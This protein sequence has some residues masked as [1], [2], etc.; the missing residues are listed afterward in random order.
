MQIKKNDKNRN[1]R[2]KEKNWIF[3][4]RIP[5]I[6]LHFPTKTINKGSNWTSCNCWSFFFLSLVLHVFLFCIYPK[7]GQRL[8]D[9]F[10][11]HFFILLSSK[12][13]NDKNKLRRRRRN[14]KY[15]Q[16][17]ELTLW[18]SNKKKKK[19]NKVVVDNLS[20]SASRKINELQSF[21]FL[22]S[23]NQRCIGY[24][25]V[26]FDVRTKEIISKIKNYKEIS[27]ENTIYSI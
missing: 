25:T 20:F 3:V 6:N 22:F 19:V 8:S 16:N 2:N 1:K 15:K 11:H 5:K 4:V 21:F 26:Q 23:G 13:T 12:Q 27:K 10:Q 14:G 18:K 17:S 9:N 7:T 24:H